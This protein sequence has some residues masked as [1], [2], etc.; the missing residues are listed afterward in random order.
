LLTKKKGAYSITNFRPISI[1]HA[2]A[3][4]VVK[5]GASTAIICMCEL[6]KKPLRVEN[7]L[8]LE[9]DIKRQSI[10]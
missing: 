7:P 5:L 1:I 6:C 9:L 4:A 8:L 3:K 2:V 10:R